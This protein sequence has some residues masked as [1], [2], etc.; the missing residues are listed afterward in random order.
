VEVGS[1]FTGTDILSA[2]AVIAGEPL[3]LAVNGVVVVEVG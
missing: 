3:R 1:P 2:R